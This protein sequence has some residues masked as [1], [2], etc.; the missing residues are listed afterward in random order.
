[1]NPYYALFPGI[2]IGILLQRFVG[3][4]RRQTNA[5][6]NPIPLIPGSFWIDKTCFRYVDESGKVRYVEGKL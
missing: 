6:E 3:R 1:M 4:S 2:L 5:I